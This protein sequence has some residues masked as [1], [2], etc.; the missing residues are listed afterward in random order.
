[1]SILITGGTGFIGS[2]L[3][4]EL[5]KEGKEVAVLDY[6][7][8]TSLLKDVGGKYKLLRGDISSLRDVMCVFLENKVTDVF[9]LASVLAEVCEENPFKGFDI[10]L[11][12]TLNLLEASRLFGV[13]KFVFISSISVFGR[14]VKEPVE[15]DAPKN[16][17]TFYGVTKLATEHICLWYNRKY[18][19]DVRG[20]RF[21]WVFGPGRKRGITRL[22]SS[23]ILDRI[24]KKGFVEIENPDEKGDWL[25][26][27]DAVKALL[28]AWKAENPKK[29][30]YNVAGGAHSIRE[31][32]EIAKKFVPDVVV[33]YKED[34]KILSPYPSS[35]DDTWAR[36]EL[37]WS[38][39]YSIEEAVRE[40]LESLKNLL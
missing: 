15:D 31:V 16:P 37:G 11:K 10:N 14:D 30:I 18:G 2:Y 3:I 12:G 20:L 33:R 25:Y 19:L 6:M 22:F 5:L 39:S 34:G 35:Y 36:K 24:A 32:V 26:V 27:K 1:M 23:E 40:H 29:R 17:L 4:K 21:T 13:K 8:D 9:H 7:P 28:L 38:P